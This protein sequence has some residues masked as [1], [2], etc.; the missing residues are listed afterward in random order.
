M[1]EISTAK[2]GLKL[3]AIAVIVPRIALHDDLAGATK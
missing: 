3:S 1:V 2:N